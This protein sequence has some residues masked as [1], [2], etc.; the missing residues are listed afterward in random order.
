MGKV[1]NPFYLFTAG[2]SRRPPIAPFSP[3]AVE[4]IYNNE[5]IL[6]FGYSRTVLQ[7]LKRAKEK[8]DFQVVVAEAYPSYGGHKM[9]SELAS[10]GIQTTAIPDATVYAMMGRVNKVRGV[11]LCT[12]TPPSA[13]SAVG[14]VC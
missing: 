12:A 4:H 3:K 10:L 2:F 8:R 5:V 9:A 11:L 14:S 13:P 7:F 6:T 1:A